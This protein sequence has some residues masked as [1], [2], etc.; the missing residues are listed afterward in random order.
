I[1]GECDALTGSFGVSA[2][3]WADAITGVVPARGRLPIELPR[4]MEAV[5]S[6]PEDVPGGTADPLYPYGHGL[7][8]DQ[9]ISS[10]R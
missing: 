4:S 7:D 1:A 9:V 2:A 10:R 3:A 6:A 8:I 5:R